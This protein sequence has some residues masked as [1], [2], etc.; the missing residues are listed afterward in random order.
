VFSIGECKSGSAAHTDIG[1]DPCRCGSG[2]EEMRRGG[3]RWGRE[4]YAGIL[5]LPVDIG[6]KAELALGLEC[7]GPGLEVLDCHRLDFGA[8][9]LIV[10]SV[11]LLWH[12]QAHR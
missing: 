1:I 4:A 6:E 5:E 11:T 8:C 2:C 12:G 7:E 10:S 9:E 3:G